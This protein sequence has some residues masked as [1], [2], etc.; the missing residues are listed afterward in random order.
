M[1]LNEKWWLKRLYCA[2]L[3]NGEILEIMALIV[4]RNL[5]TG[6]RGKYATTIKQGFFL[7]KRPYQMR[8]NKHRVS[9]H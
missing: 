3:L 5:S 4:T 7:C 9:T 6:A 1:E 8:S 2:N